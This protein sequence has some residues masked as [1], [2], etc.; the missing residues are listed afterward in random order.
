MTYSYNNNNKYT[1]IIYVLYQAVGER[2][3]KKDVHYQAVG[4]RE[5]KK[6]IMFFLKTL[7]Q[8]SKLVSNQKILMSY[9]RVTAATVIKMKL[10]LAR[11]I[12]VV[13]LRI[14]SSVLACADIPEFFSNQVQEKYIIHIY[15]LY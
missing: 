12:K 4:E 5:S 3:S 11:G 9:E 1:F 13:F 15:L 7:Q 8:W 14:I 6:E 10:G 2:Q